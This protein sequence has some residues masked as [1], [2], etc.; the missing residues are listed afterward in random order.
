MFPETDKRIE[1]LQVH[2][3][4]NPNSM[5]FARLADYLLESGKVDQ[6]III[7][8]E[9]LKKHPY[10]VSGHFVMGKC[11]LKKELYDQAEKEFKRVLFLDPKYL[12]AHKL[13]ADIM[14]RIGWENAIETSYQKILEIDPLNTEIRSKLMDIQA[15]KVPEI[16]PE[17]EDNLPLETEDEAD[18]FSESTIPVEEGYVESEDTADTED[19]IDTVKKE[20]AEQ[21]PEDNE[22]ITENDEEKFSSIIDEIFEE[23][24]AVDEKSLAEEPDQK[25]E[26][27]FL[28]PEAENFTLDEHG[29][30]ILDEPI[31]F[32]EP[33]E[34]TTQDMETAISAPQPEAK[35]PPEVERPSKS[36][37]EFE[38]L[39]E[40]EETSIDRELQDFLDFQDQKPS[41]PFLEVPDEELLPAQDEPEP[42]PPGSKKK[43]KIVTPTLGE[44][45]AAQGQY[46]K[47]IGVFEILRK[48]EPN[49]K[50]YTEKIEYLKRKLEESRL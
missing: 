13:Y 38:P 31:D 29:T 9:G 12:A 25:D 42:T 32:E 10:Y 21:L 33:F 15:V 34:D 14:H 41:P 20:L 5:L 8:E 27:D 47:A 24:V 19:T 50:A 45:Y 37:D 7:C 2:L 36:E 49:N 17:L 46:A 26:F 18:I 3:R 22:P 40:S 23:D 16:E 28:H 48:K 6:A 4:A 43:G 44:I 39:P 30:S 35:S 11:Y 1:D